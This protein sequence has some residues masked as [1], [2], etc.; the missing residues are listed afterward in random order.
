MTTSSPVS[1]RMPAPSEPGITGRS[2][3]YAGPGGL[4]TSRSRR[5]IAAALQLDD[6]LAGPG[7][8]V[9]VV[10]VRERPALDD[11]NGFH[12]SDAQGSSAETST[13]T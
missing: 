13:A 2:N 6:D 8:R 11:R 3:S 9:G 4:R 12:R 10:P 7:D 5:L 1:R